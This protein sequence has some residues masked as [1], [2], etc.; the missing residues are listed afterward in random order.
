MA[1]SGFR[2]R[3]PPSRSIGPGLEAWRRKVY[4]A[5]LAVARLLASEMEADMKQDAPWTD[6]TGAARRQLRTAIQEVAGKAVELYLIHGVEYGV[7][8]ETLHAG[9]YEVIRPVLIRN[10]GKIQ[11]KLQA[12]FR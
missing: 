8:L 2:W 9:R 11:G 3:T 10:L 1:G 5:T 4:G 6:Q 7:Y 12:I